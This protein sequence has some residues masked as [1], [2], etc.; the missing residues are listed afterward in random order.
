[1][2][3]NRNIPQ[4]TD[5]ISNSQP[6]LLANFQAI[7][8]GTTGTGIGFARN[9]VTMTDATNG[10]LHNRIDFYQS[11][12]TP[13]S[14]SGFVSSLY[15]Q[16]IFGAMELCYTNTNSVNTQITSGNLD[17]WKGGG[18][19]GTG[20]VTA[21]NAASGAL[22]LPN[23]IQFRW[24]SMSCNTG[25]TPISYSAPFSTVNGTYAVTLTPQ[26]NSSRGAA[27]NS[28]TANGFTAFA[29]NNGTLM[30]YFAVG[31]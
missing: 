13:V 12:A 24:G 14:V 2:A 25:G 29:E 7:D 28:L 27:V 10:G 21:T 8:S 4:P 17:I 20:V 11:I 26:G 30:Y 31:H 23:G 16:N 1:M 15:P 5:L 9:H 18:P 6:S 22:N 19:G 3:Y